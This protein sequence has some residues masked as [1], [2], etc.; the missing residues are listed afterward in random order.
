M[1]VVRRH[2]SA[3]Q[4]RELIAK[5]L[6]ADPEQSDRQVGK[7]AK[8]DHKTVAAVRAAKEGRGEIPHV[9]KRADTKGRRQPV[10]KKKPV[11]TKTETTTTETET[12]QLEADEQIFAAWREIERFTDTIIR[13]D[14]ELAQ[15]LF[16]ILRDDVNFEGRRAHE[17]LIQ[18]L[19]AG[20]ALA[21]QRAAPP[22]EAAASPRAAPAFTPVA[23]D[24]Y[25]D[26]PAS[27][28]RTPPAEDADA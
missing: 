28:R 2:L 9:S 6:K 12:R 25:P 5:L 23:P 27:L 8:V 15:R 18:A 1:N 13:S 19:E 10:K 3:E 20:L 16:T 14:V 22:I 11:T 26:L 4:K 7:M 17:V 24:D 21:S